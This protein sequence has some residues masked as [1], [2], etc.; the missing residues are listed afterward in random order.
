MGTGQVLQAPKT[1][2]YDK[3]MFVRLP[4]STKYF[5]L[6]QS[7]T[8]QSSTFNNLN[9]ATTTVTF[10]SAK[11]VQIT[12]GIIQTHIFIPLGVLGD[13]TSRLLRCIW[14]TWGII[15]TKTF[16]SFLQGFFVVEGQ[17]H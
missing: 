7:T 16:D 3:K 2:R 13:H 11:Y 8:G 5:L 17:F 15:K 4:N 12:W 6:I 10:H 1:I 14:I 9:R